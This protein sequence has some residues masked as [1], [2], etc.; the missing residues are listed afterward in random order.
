MSLS[1]VFVRDGDRFRPTELARGPWD[2]R[3]LHGGAPAALIVHA[4]E[5]CEPAAALRLARVTYEFLRPVPLEPLT[6][7]AEVVRPGRRVMLLEA[8]IRDPAGT[9]VV[10]ARALRVRPSEL[11]E[12][13]V[14]AGE[15]VQGGA[16]PFPGPSEGRVSDFPRARSPMFA[17]DAM[18]IRFVEG[19]FLEMGSA[20]AWFRLRRPLIGGESATPLQLLAAAGDFGNGIASVLSWEAHVFINPD[21]TLV[22]ER[23]PRGEWVAL[24]SR[25]RV[26]PGA[27]AVAESVLWD[28]RGRLGAA[29]QTLLVSRR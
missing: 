11:G 29:T 25:M 16:V 9:E 7:H 12:P 22:I 3:A 17:T 5:S 26:S 23:E 24:Q 13:P 19:N 20:T 8:S 18:E 2:P 10:R 14:E 1:S 21:L 4:L 27:V 28:E 6:V 15:R